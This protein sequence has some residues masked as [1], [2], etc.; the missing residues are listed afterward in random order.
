MK[1]D[2]CKFVAIDEIDDLYNSD[3]DS[4]K[5]LLEILVKQK[6]TNIIACSATMEKKFLDFYNTMDP[7]FQTLNINQQLKEEHSGQNIT[8]EGLK[9][10]YKEIKHEDS[11]AEIYDYIIKTLFKEL[12]SDSTKMKPQLFMFFNSVNDI[13]NF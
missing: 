13:A 11:K 2:D 3:E 1:L 8:I 5:M 9:N 6:N 4:L 7:D 12:F 10:F